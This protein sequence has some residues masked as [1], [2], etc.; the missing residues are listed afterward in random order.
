MTIIIVTGED[1][2]DALIRDFKQWSKSRNVLNAFDKELRQMGRTMKASVQAHVLA[3]PSKNQNARRGRRS[4]R[5][6]ISRAVTWGH[7]Q[8]GEAAGVIVK[9]DTG[10]MPTGERGL[11][12]LYEGVSLWQHPVYGHKPIVMQKPH[13]YFGPATDSASAY[14]EHVGE[15]GVDKIADDLE[16]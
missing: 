15:V 14:L 6:E 11:P 10:K 2:L 13:P 16:G 5:K 4:L 7:W 9:V 8:H 12:K 3:T 1:E